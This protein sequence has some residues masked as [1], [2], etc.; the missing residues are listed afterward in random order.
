MVRPSSDDMGITIQ[1]PLTDIAM[2]RDVALCE[3]E[4]S[5][6]HDW[7]EYTYHLSPAWGFEQLKLHHIIDDDTVMS[8]SSGL[9]MAED[10]LPNC[11]KLTP[12]GVEL[13]RSYEE[14]C[15]R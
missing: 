4:Q 7:C 15:S 3:P 8:A 11:R 5:T 12:L 9:R 2:L 14:E 13:M 6:P 10:I 1:I